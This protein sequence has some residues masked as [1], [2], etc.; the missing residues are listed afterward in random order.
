VE[1]VER[2]KRHER[3]PLLGA[4]VDDFLVRPLRQVVPVLDRRDRNDLAPALELLDADLG[5]PDVP[6]LPT[7][8]VRGD[9][10][11]A[12]LEWG[13]GVDAVQVVEVDR[14]GAQAPQTLLDLRAQRLRAAGTGR[15]AALRRD[16]QAARA[17]R[18]GFAGRR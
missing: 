3:D 1:A 7:V 5:E 12:L 13:L 9:R 14:V 2:E 17:R 18:Q 4:V 11:E 6:D 16:D 10:A 8:T 15:V